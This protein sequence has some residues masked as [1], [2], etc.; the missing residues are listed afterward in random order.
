M[1]EKEQHIRFLFLH[2]QKARSPFLLLIAGN[3]PNFFIKI[4]C[5][6][7]RAD[8][9]FKLVGENGTSVVATSNRVTFKSI[10][11]P[12]HG[13]LA[14]DENANEMRVMWTSNSGKTPVVKY[15]T[16]SGKL[17]NVVY[18]SSYTYNISEMCDKPA[19]T[20]GA[21]IDPGYINDAVIPNLKPGWN[22]AVYVF[23]Q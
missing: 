14:L 19:N 16:A 11:E 9:I 2:F 1:E 8:Y 17:D 12:I 21:W 4:D 7:F 22:N 15:G 23:S 3:F 20:S 13:H 10:D 18:G 5:F 6:E